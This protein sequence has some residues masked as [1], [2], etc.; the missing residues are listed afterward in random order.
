MHT[1]LSV[2]FFRPHFDFSFFLIPF[3][4][5]CPSFPPISLDFPS[6]PFPLICLP[7]PSAASNTIQ[8][9]KFTS[10]SLLTYFHWLHLESCTQKYRCR[11][12]YVC[13][14]AQ[15]LIKTDAHCCINR[16][17]EPTLYLKIMTHYFVAFAALYCCYSFLQ[18]CFM[19]Q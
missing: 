2:Y 9:D 8:G 11:N 4:L 15:Q 17:I 5:L 19:L 10:S 1:T 14:F 16:D 6:P 3:F 13:F 7:L 18:F 12:G